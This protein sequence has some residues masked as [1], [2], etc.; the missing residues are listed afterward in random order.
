MKKIILFMFIFFKVLDVSAKTYY[1]DYG[2]YKEIDELGTKSDVVDYKIVDKYL[3][4]KE[5]KTEAFYPSYMEIEDMVKTGETKIVTSSWLDEKPDE[6]IGRNIIEGNLYEYQNMKKIRYL[7]LTGL[8]IS[9]GLFGLRELKIENG[10]KKIN[11][12]IITKLDNIEKIQ[13][14]DLN[15]YALFKDTDEVW[16]DF[17]ESV[18]INNLVMT[19][20]I[21]TTYETPIYFTMDLLGEECKD[22]YTTR[23][24]FTYP[25]NLSPVIPI[26]KRHFNILVNPLYEEK[27]LSEEY[28]EKNNFN[29]VNKVKKYKTEDLYIKYE[30]IKREYL[31]DYYDEPINEYKLDIDSKKQFYYV[32]TRDKVEI[33]DYLTINNYDMQLEDLIISATTPNIKI[34]SNMS[35]CVNGKYDINFILPFKTIKEKLIVDIK[36]NYI[37]TLEVQ[38]NYLKTLEEENNKLIISN[39]KLNTEI[40][41]ILKNKD[42]EVNEVN[43]K[44]IACKYELEDLK[45][46][47]IDLDEEIVEKKDHRI[48][49]SISF[50]LGLAS[51]PF[52]LRKKSIQNNN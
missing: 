8:I 38:N 18:D 2:E 25:T 30:K 17:K 6:L 24:L 44:I 13:D 3:I 36:E 21:Y 42:K 46:N 34:T 27:E 29:I 51:V 19:F 47:R 50:V 16:I 37:N 28:I 20:S 49:I 5:N 39:N 4:Y 43:E 9:D 22:V 1:S 23:N 12:E 52:L 35:Y 31:E 14:N 26:T 7:K 40:K 33:S 10:S 11:Y 41:E 48:L 45:E 32:R 15:N